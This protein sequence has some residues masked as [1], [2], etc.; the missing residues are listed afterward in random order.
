MVKNSFLAALTLKINIFF[1]LHC[2]ILIIFY[3]NWTVPRVLFDWAREVP[4]SHRFS[5][6]N[7]RLIYKANTY[8]K[9]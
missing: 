7:K 5:S 3:I 1:R 4:Q 9:E 6:R 2:N 8:K